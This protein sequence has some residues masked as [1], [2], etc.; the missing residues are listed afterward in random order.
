MK[1]IRVEVLLWFTVKADTIADAENLLND[2]R[3]KNPQTAETVA[4]QYVGAWEIKTQLAEID[5]V[6]AAVVRADSGPKRRGG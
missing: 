4:P 3:V 6:G 1:P 5:P 2:L